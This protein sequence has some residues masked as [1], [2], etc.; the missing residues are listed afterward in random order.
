MPITSS[1]F[2]IIFFS[3]TVSEFDLLGVALCTV[4]DKDLVLR[5][6]I[7]KTAQQP[8]AHQHQTVH[9]PFPNKVTH[10]NP[11]STLCGQT[12]AGTDPRIRGSGPIQPGVV[13]QAGVPGQIVL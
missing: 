1:F 12:H 13:L 7:C 3:S 10:N 11:L 9:T 2:F 4:R 6:V 5:Q 8:G